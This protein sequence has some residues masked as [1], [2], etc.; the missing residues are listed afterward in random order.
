MPEIIVTIFPNLFF[1]VRICI[2]CSVFAISSQ[3]QACK[4][5]PHFGHISICL[6]VFNRFFAFSLPFLRKGIPIFVQEDISLFESS[7]SE[8]NLIPNG[9]NID[10]SDYQ[11]IGPWR[12]QVDG[13]EKNIISKVYVRNVI[14]SFSKRG[15][16][17]LDD[18]YFDTSSWSSGATFMNVGESGGDDVYLAVRLIS[19]TIP[20]DATI[21]SATITLRHDSNQSDTVLAKM[22]GIDEDDTAN[23]SSNPISRDLTTAQVNTSIPT[24]SFEDYTYPDIS[25]IVQ[26]IVNRAGWSSG[27]AM[28]F[29]LNNNSTGA[30]GSRIFETYDGT[31]AQAALLEVEYAKTKTILFR[32]RTRYIT[33]R[34]DVTI[35]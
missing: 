1:S 30:N 20:K 15:A 11:I 19:V 13:D 25:T 8:A 6:F 10:T 4:G 7:I 3:T 33:P 35:T 21:V 29:I 22:N 27:N 28:G 23:F 5:N 18:G 14:K 26:E 17:G 34:R 32:G 31:P 16:A 12:E 2:L 24:L 9:S